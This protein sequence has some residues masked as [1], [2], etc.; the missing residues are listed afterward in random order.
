[1]LGAIDEVVNGATISMNGTGVLKKA[2]LKA[3]A[4]K[5]SRAASYIVTSI[6]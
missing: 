2:V 6:L 3:M 1:M 5:L 4:K